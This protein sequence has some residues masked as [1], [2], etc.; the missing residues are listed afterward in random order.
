VNTSGSRSP[1]SYVA[2]LV[3]DLPRS[4]IRDFFDIVSTRKDVVS[5]GIGEPDF[6]TPWR[7]REAAIFAIEEGA[8]SYTSNR[9]LLRLR[10]SGSARRWIWLSGPSRRR[11]TRSF[12]TSRVMSR[13]GP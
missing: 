6:V 10:R 13:T 1:R 5:L 12:T 2:P 8:T 7:I 3:R 9:G 11:A 4:G